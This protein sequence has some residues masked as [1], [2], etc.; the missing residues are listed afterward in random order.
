MITEIQKR[1]AQTLTVNQKAML[2]AVM[3]EIEDSESIE[4]LRNCLLSHR[5]F[6]ENVMHAERIV[7]LHDLTNQKQ[8]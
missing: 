1:L 2:A 7:R 6:D 5:C 3:Q 4:P 8:V